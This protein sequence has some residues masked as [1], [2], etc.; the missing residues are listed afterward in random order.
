MVTEVS[1]LEPLVGRF[2]P[3]LIL[4][5]PLIFAYRYFDIAGKESKI[6]DPD[7]IIVGPLSF[8]IAGNGSK[9]Y[10]I[11]DLGFGASG[12]RAKFIEK[13][14]SRF[15]E[16]MTFG[17]QLEMA[18]AVH[19]HWPNEETAQLLAIAVKETKSEPTKMVGQHRDIADSRFA[20]ALRRDCGNPF[21]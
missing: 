14:E 4:I 9:V 20:G 1:D 19:E 7:V 2:D 21:V 11:V 10:E 18:N 6:F 3:G 5:G 12:Q 16:V 15:A 13:L 8:D 17:S